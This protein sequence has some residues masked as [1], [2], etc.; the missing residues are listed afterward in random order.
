[1]A[2]DLPWC[3]RE[4]SR[5][6]VR[7]CICASVGLC[8]PTVVGSIA[9]EEGLHATIR[10]AQ[11]RFVKRPFEPRSYIPYRCQTLAAPAT[12]ALH[13]A[14]GPPQFDWAKLKGE[15]VRLNCARAR[16]AHVHVYTM[17]AGGSAQYHMPGVTVVLSINQ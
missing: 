11:A 14:L 16:N 6:C 15:P 7:L 2:S 17:H 4:F 1:M 3:P 13:Y 5:V 8:A 10:D 12:Y 9:S